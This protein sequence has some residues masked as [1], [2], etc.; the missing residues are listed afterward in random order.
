MK[1]ILS[2]KGFDSGTGGV[3]S[4]IFPSG[5]LRSIP[6]PEPIPDHHSKRYQEIRAGDHPLG[7][8]VSDLTRGKIQPET[9]AHLD[10]D[11][12]AGSIPRLQNWRPIFGQA[13]AAE[14]HLQNQG[15][16]EGDVFVFYGWFRQVELVS[17]KYR[18]VS[19]APD[20]HVIFGWLQVE[21][22]L[23]VDSLSEIP[24]WARDHP[25]C[26]DRK[27][28]PLD[29][30]YISTNHLH[31]PGTDISKPGAGVFHKFT[32]ELQLT[33]PH[34]SKSIWQLPAWFYP[35]EPS[36]SLSYHRNL[37]RW[38]LDGDRVLL[39]SVGR[40]QEFVL[41]C[42]EY[43]EAVQWLCQ[44]LSLNDQIVSLHLVNLLE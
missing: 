17:G 42:Q 7:S 35:R 8:I 33:A 30:I 40:G 3:A 22:R 13:G 28:N 21:Q 34:Q 24:A 41:D 26:K 16:K 25:H 9:F 20:L 12:D 23:S 38:K 15:V 32:P 1:I 39:Q 11:L 2:R 27:Y 5:E 44:L 43:P 4:P 14:K 36:S 31:L 19:A 18:Y 29:S 6:I 37:N 10:P